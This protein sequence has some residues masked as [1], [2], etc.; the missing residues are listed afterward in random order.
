MFESL[1][2]DRRIAASAMLLTLAS[3]ALAGCTEG[4]GDNKEKAAELR[5]VIA[6][7]VVFEPR[8]ATRS[9]VG[10]VRPRV[11]SDLG[12]RVGGKVAERL[13]QVGDRVKA[14]QALA[15]LDTVDL[16]LQ[17]EQAQAELAAAKASLLSAELEDRRIGQLRVEGW[18]TASAA[19][20]QKAAVEE[21]RGRRSRAERAVSLAANSLDYATLKA[22]ADGIVTATLVEPGQVVAQGAPSIRLAKVDSR[23]AVAAIPEALIERVRTAKADVSLWSEPDRT[24]RARLRELSPSADPATRTYQAR[25]TILD[26]PPTLEFGLT[27]TVTLSDPESEKVARLPLSALFN[28]GRGANVF[29]VDPATGALALKPV[30]VAAY[31]STDVV[32]RSGVAA[33]D[34]VVTLGVQKLD[35][36]QRVRIVQR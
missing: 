31:E 6:Q 32:L 20:K 12:F 27:A 25:F 13:V 28:Q 24:Y 1:Q 36:A 7:P 11:E 30:E 18:S 10:V 15:A 14:G 34:M 22:D 26:A 4:K 16:K 5:A 2:Q 35:V 8:A 21:A 23:E 9:F 17:L 19:E 29:V 33:G 3:V